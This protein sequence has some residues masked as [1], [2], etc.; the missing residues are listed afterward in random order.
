MNSDN[1]MDSTITII[2]L[3][4]THL[5]APYISY[6]MIEVLQKVKWEWKKSLLFYSRRWNARAWICQD[7]GNFEKCPHCDIALAYHTEPRK[8][9][10]CH[11]CNYKTPL[12]TS[13]PKCSWNTIVWVWTGIGKIESDLKNILGWV[14]SILRI[15]SDVWKKYKDFFDAI[16]IHD[17]I[18]G[19]NMA[20]LISHRDIGAVFFLSF[21]MNLSLPEYD[22]EERI[23]SEISYYKKQN[24]PIYIQTYS[25]EHPLLHEIVFWNQK[26]FFKNLVSERK[27]FLYPPFSEM[28]IIRVHEREKTQVKKLIEHLVRKI[29]LIKEDS[30]FLAFDQDMLEKHGEKYIQK[31]VLKSKNLSYILPHI[32]TE[33]MRHRSITLEWA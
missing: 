6:E 14:Y 33:C 11:I 24:I 7:C 16:D 30:T 31:I 8:H 19:T 18:L 27:S 28:L 23:F 1:L 2:P 9:L 29:S 13:C 25:P 20:S 4:T 10:V 15:D 5:H 17:I 3:A 22:M 21:E 26:S 32:E 12:H